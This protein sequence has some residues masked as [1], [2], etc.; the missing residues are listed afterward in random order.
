MKRFVSLSVFLAA[1]ML[2]CNIGTVTPEPATD[3]PTP[4]EPP[5]TTNV[6]CNELSLYL[7]PALASGYSCETI[8]ESTEEFAV[9]PQHTQVTLQGYVLADRFFEPMIRVFPV[10]RYSELL[11][12]SNIPGRVATLQGLIGGAAPS[13]SGLPFLPVFNAG[14]TFTDQYQVLAY[15]DGGGIRYLTLFAQYYAPINNHELIYTYQALTSDG[16]YWISVILPI[17]HPI[18]PENAD[19]PPPGYTWDDL[20]Y[21]YDV[22]LDDVLPQL[23]AQVANFVPLIDALDALAA[24]ITIQP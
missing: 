18:L 22:Y 21:H 7:D 4:T 16:Q 11:P 6:T 20:A 9:M 24:S 3:T 14:E 12:D 10:Q 2:A 23:D 19:N 15:H 8:P 5:V 17:S 1:L 13:G